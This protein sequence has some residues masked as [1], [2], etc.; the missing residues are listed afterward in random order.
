M[1]KSHP[2]HQADCPLCNNAEFLP[3]PSNDPLLL[4]HIKQNHLPLGCRK[5][6]IIVEK[7]GDQLN[8][9]CL[10]VKLVVPPDITVTTAHAEKMPDQRAVEIKEAALLIETPKSKFNLKLSQTTYP[11]TGPLSSS[12]LIKCASAAYMSMKSNGV[13]T[14]LIRSTSTPTAT[15]ELVIPHITLNATQMSSIY[16]QSSELVT[17]SPIG[18]GMGC[19]PGAPKV[20]DKFKFP[21]RLKNSSNVTPLR[22]VM[23]QNVQ[24]ALLNHEFMT[25]PQHS[26]SK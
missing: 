19:T 12:S 7:A 6:A 13:A 1:E 21:M 15:Q 23:S 8:E 2:E 4:A 5:C 11:Q 26:N 25:Q 18:I 14:R 3:F 16:N 9:T 22:Q 17:N 24:R 10:L 20:V